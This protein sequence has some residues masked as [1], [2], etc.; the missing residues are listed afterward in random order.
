MKK[1]RTTIFT[2][3]LLFLIIFLP[4]SYLLVTY[5][6][7]EDSIL[8]KKGDVKEVIHESKSTIELT[9]ELQ[10]KEILRL[11]QELDS[12]RINK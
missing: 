4:I 9:V 5:L 3:L 6:K 12:C 11:Q 1:H 8:N 10:R 2:R 7:G